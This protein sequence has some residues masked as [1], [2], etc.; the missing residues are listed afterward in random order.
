MAAALA[1]EIRALRSEGHELAAVAS[2]QRSTAADFASQHG[3]AAGFGSH[4][5][6]VQHDGIDAVYIATPHRLHAANAL[7]CIAGGK[8]VLCEKPFTINAEEAAGVIEAARRRRVFVMEAMWT[9][10]LP[11]IVTLRR[12]LRDGAIGRIDTI[13]GGGAFIPAP[14]PGNYLFDP[15]L[16]GGVLLDAGVY[17]VSLAS[18]ILGTPTRMVASGL[19]GEQGIDERVSMVL[20]HAGGGVAQLYVSLRARRSPDLEI[21][22]DRGRIRLEA[23]VFRPPSLAVWDAAGNATSLACPIQGS[24]YGYQLREVA[25]ALAAGRIESDIM[26]LSE[27]LSIMRTMDVVRD[28][29]GLRYPFE[30]RSAAGG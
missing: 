11:S 9:R 4:E 21:L 5:E 14:A 6:L 3:I 10:F 2:R 12:L 13:V 8:A 15:E 25:A 22:G 27:S 1:T 23:P 24:G 20:E 26:P 19:V 17:L 7:A 16:G 29:I 28:Q 30:F 18:M